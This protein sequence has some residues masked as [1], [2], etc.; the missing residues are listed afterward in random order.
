MLLFLFVYDRWQKKNAEIFVKTF[1]N[2]NQ[3]TKE[4]MRECVWFDIFKAIKFSVQKVLFLYIVDEDDEWMEEKGI[5]ISFR[6]N[7]HTTENKPNL[8]KVYMLTTTMIAAATATT[9]DNAH[10]TIALLLSSLC[11]VCI[12][13]S[14]LLNWNDRNRV[15]K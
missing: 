8:Q 15:Y 12:V 4:V 13:R 3:S 14:V 11:A 7:Q 5:K 10:D 9:D 2:I 6:F 1:A